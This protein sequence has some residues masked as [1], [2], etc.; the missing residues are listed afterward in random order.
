[1]V[2][3]LPNLQPLCF[4]NDA[5]V[6]GVEV[7][8]PRHSN[9][10]TYAFAPLRSFLSRVSVR[11]ILTVAAL[12]CPVFSP[13]LGRAQQKA[14]SVSDGPRIEV[15]ESSE[16]QHETLQ[17]KPALT[18]GATRTPNLTI[19]VNDAVKYQQ[20][21]GFGASLTDSSAWLLWNKLTETQRKEALQMLFSPSKGIGLSVLRQ[22]MGASDFALTDYT[23]DDLPPGSSQQATRNCSTSPLT[24][25]T[26][27]SFRF[28]ARRSFSI[29]TSRSSPL[30]G[31]LR[32]G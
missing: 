18:F 23:Y 21:D 19:A 32:A 3:K 17:D 15:V 10:C 12:L 16:D 30:P 25:T 8:A 24:T 28:Y 26:R 11:P 1:M 27:T 22:P 7:E 4:D 6:G 5:T 14:P 9:L 2:Y 31:V 13:A 29:P 20:I